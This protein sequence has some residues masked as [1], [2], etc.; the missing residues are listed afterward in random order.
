ME[1][2]VEWKGEGYAKNSSLQEYYAHNFIYNNPLFPQFEHKG[3]NSTVLIDIGCGDGRH[4]RHIYEKVGGIVYGID[5]TPKQIEHARTTHTVIG[6]KSC[7]KYFIL[8]ATQL[9]TLKERYPD[10]VIDIEV[11]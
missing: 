3:E 6:D 1:G 8:D 2:K 5:L 11:K 10:E 7:L 9:D 4:T